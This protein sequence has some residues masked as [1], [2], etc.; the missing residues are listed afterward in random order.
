MTFRPA[1]R[2]GTVVLR[3]DARHLQVG[4][5]P[6]TVVAD[7]P[8][9]H[10]LLLA[11]DGLHGSTWL[12]DRVPEVGDVDEALAPLVA[13]GVV[14]DA[15]AWDARHLEE[16]R[17]LSLSGRDPGLLASRRRLH[18]WLHADPGTRDLMDTVGVVLDAAG[19]SRRHPHDAD[20]LVIASSGEPPRAIFAEA[21]HRQVPHLAVRVEE[22]RVHVGPFVAPGTSPCLG[23]HDLHRID[24]DPAWA[25]LIPQFGAR[26]AQHNPPALGAVLRH[27]AAAEIAA[28]I[29]AVADGDPTQHAASVLAIGPGLDDRHRWPLAFHHRCLCALLPAA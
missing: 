19:V 21:V 23:C 12:A 10:R 1:L 2:P 4:T 27:V 26:G 6:G 28:G 20:L 8:G 7:R 24:W 14:V 29:I 5:S 22:D 3:R 13:V 25:A 11:L 15:G 18:V 9:L 16:A 17:H